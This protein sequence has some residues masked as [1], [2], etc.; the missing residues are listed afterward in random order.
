VLGPEVDIER[1]Q[2]EHRRGRVRALFGRTK[3]ARRQ[4]FERESLRLRG[5]LERRDHDHDIT[6]PVRRDA[7][8]DHV[9]PTGD[10]AVHERVLEDRVRAAGSDPRKDGCALAQ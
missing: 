8:A 7:G 3:I 4:A 6:D 9:A 10:D 5:A 1:P 2:D